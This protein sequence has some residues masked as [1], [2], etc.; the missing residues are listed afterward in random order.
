MNG[1]ASLELVNWNV[2]EG[3]IWYHWCCPSGTGGSISACTTGGS[4][5]STGSDSTQATSRVVETLSVTEPPA[6]G[7]CSP[8]PVPNTR[9][10]WL[11]DATLTGVT[12]TTAEPPM[13]GSA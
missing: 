10:T 2:T 9:D 3:R 11:P 5:M 8:A 13:M 6:L 12:T 1:D 7:L 4:V